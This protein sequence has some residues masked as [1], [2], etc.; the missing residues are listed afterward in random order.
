MNQVGPIRM[1]SERPTSVDC[2]RELGRLIQRDHG[3]TCVDAEQE[4]QTSE[5][6]VA[7]V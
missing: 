6:I 5:K 1:S 4:F 3:P 7:D 2:L